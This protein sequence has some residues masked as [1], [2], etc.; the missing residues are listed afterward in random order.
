MYNLKFKSH[1]LSILYFFLTC[2]FAL[3]II[4]S[5]SFLDKKSKYFPSAEKTSSESVII[6]TGKVIPRSEE[7]LNKKIPTGEIE[8]TVEN[9]VNGEK[10]IGGLILPDTNWKI[11]GKEVHMG[12]ERN[13][14]VLKIEPNGELTLIALIEDGKRIDPPEEE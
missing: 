8:I 1:I 7:T 14:M 13:K 6:V 11:V 2:T 10:K 3:L 4:I 9:Y 5:L 12:V